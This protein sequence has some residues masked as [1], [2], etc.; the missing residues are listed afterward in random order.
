MARQWPQIPE[1]TPE[2]REASWKHWAMEQAVV[3]CAAKA[4]EVAMLPQTAEL[5]YRWTAFHHPP[6]PAE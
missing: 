2:Q 3:L 1:S 6:K 5:I 4:I